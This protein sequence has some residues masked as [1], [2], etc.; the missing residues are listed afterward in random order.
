MRFLIIAWACFATIVAGG[1]AIAAPEVIHPTIGDV[2]VERDNG[3]V[4]K[5]ELFVPLVHVPESVAFRVKVLTDGKTVIQSFTIDVIQFKRVSHGIPYGPEKKSIT[6]ARIVADSFD[7]DHVAQRVDM[8][9]GGLGYIF[10]DNNALASLLDLIQRG[11]YYLTFKRSD[12]VDTTTYVVSDKV[13]AKVLREFATC[14][15]A[16]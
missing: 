4:K 13:P 15:T 10:T 7:S 12:K 11:D 2:D 9:D 16:L 14:A 1:A 6:A 8:G 5:C 3:P